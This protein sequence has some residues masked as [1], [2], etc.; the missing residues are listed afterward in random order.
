LIGESTHPI[1]KTGA[2]TASSFLNNSHEHGYGYGGL[3]AIRSDN[4]KGAWCAASKFS[5]EWIQITFPKAT[6]ISR[7]EMHQGRDANGNTGSLKTFRVAWR[8]SRASEFVTIDRSGLPIDFMALGTSISSS[9]T[10]S[11]IIPNVIAKEVRIIPTSW[12]G[13][14][15]LRLEMY[16]PDAGTIVVAPLV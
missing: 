12:T 1:S 7:V 8:T 3:D 13:V 11:V 10:A 5:S 14:P 4:T 6:V 15:C 16:G 2:L 9:S